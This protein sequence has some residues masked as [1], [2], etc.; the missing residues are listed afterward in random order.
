MQGYNQAMPRRPGEHAP[1]QTPDIKMQE[2]KK[3][4]AL[5]PDSAAT[6]VAARSGGWGDPATWSTGA[7]PR[8]GDRVVIPEG[9]VV[10]VDGLYDRYRIDRLRV[11]GTLRFDPTVD[12]SLKAV[13]TVASKRGT[14]EVGTA[15]APVRP[16]RVASFVI[17]DRGERDAA[18]RA[19]D[20][21]DLTGSFIAMGVVR[22]FGAPKVSHATPQDL[23]R[24]GDGQVTFR[25]APAG[26][27]VGDRLLFAGLTLGRNDD[28]VRVITAISADGRTCTLDQPLASNHGGIYGFPGAAPV[29]NLT[30]NVVFRSEEAADGTRRGHIMFMHTLDVRIDSAEFHELGRTDARRKF[31]FPTV[32]E[33]GKPVAGSDNNTIGRYAIHFHYRA[34][35]TLDMTPAFV[36]ASAVEGSPK[37]GI[38]NHGGHVRIEDNVTHRVNG[39]HIFMENG[40]EIGTVRGNMCVRSNG[41]GDPGFRADVPPGKP[42]DFGHGGHGVWSQSGGVVI[43]GNFASGHSAAAYELFFFGQP[44]VSVPGQSNAVFLTR[45]LRDPS[46]AGGQ[47]WVN[48]QTVP[49][50]FARNVG[51]ASAIGLVTWDLNLDASL[52]QGRNLIERCL[53]VLNGQGWRNDYSRQVTVRDT[54]FIGTDPNAFGNPAF[55][56][57]GIGGNL[58]TANIELENVTIDGYASGY[59]APEHGVNTIRGGYINGIGKVDV[60]P[61]WGGGQLIIDGVTWGTLK[62]EKPY[63]I[64]LK[65]E[66]QSDNPK[67]FPLYFQPF[68]LVYNGRHVYYDGQ[69]AD[70]VPFPTSGVDFGPEFV[71]KTN[72]Q[73][74]KQYRLAIGGRIAPAGLE[75]SPDISG[76]AFGPDVPF[77]PSILMPTK[78]N[79]DNVYGWPVPNVIAQD[80]DY[81]A[82]VVIGGVAYSSAPVDLRRGWNLIRIRTR[83][84]PRYIAVLH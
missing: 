81:V 71:G 33:R 67:V 79:L 53:F 51:I 37:N 4:M 82:H 9:K 83:G 75:A 30:R 23:P 65:N 64:R 24:P 2:H 34:G 10:T 76:G 48:P 54:H 15:E 70:V 31:T 72:R 44:D 36:H 18:Q 29:G 49:V 35:A 57:L 62:G 80:R 41:S 61:P 42:F 16:D 63:K 47:P 8:T 38:V 21:S 25:D 32:D 66:F 59:N 77:D 69:G 13:T 74:W 19:R 56:G 84:A 58:E 14:V 28:E 43:T 52:R 20:P 7:V 78:E 26:W 3:A 5:V 50:Y 12:T 17:G 6:V 39:S 11:D 22:I 60:A 46:I 1:G 40:S 27:R 73:L 55:H 68:R 45:N